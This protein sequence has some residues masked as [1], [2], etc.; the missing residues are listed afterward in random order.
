MCLGE[1]HISVVLHCK[2]GQHTM[3]QNCLAMGWGKDDQR[4][5]RAVRIFE[6]GLDV[7]SSQ[8]LEMMLFTQVKSSFRLGEQR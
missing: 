8:D 4:N 1:E 7:L 2:H 6:Y 3:S 5:D